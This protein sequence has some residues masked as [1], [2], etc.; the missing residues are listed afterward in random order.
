MEDNVTKLHELTPTQ[1]MVKKITDDADAAGVKVAEEKK[2]EE[3][4][5]LDGDGNKPEEKV[6]PI[7]ERIKETYDYTHFKDLT[8]DEIAEFNKA[9]PNA[10]MRYRYIE[11]RNDVKKNQRLVSERQKTIDDMTE[12]YSD[13]KVK[14]HEAFIDALKKDTRGGWMKHQDEFGLPDVSFLEKQ[15][16]EGNSI[17]D[18][19]AQYQ[20]TQLIPD[21]EKKFNLEKGTFVYDPAD[22]HKAKT[23]SFNFRTATEDKS[24]ELE[25]EHTKS[26]KLAED[27]IQ[28]AFEH[29]KNDM[30][31]LKEDYF[32][33]LEIKDN[34]SD[35]DKGTF[36]I[37]NEQADGKFTEL[38]GNIDEMFTKIKE[39][40]FSH[41]KN[42]LSLNNIFRGVHFDF[43]VDRIRTEAVENVHQQYRDKGMYLRGEDGKPLPTNLTKVQ[44]A[45]DVGSMDYL[46]EAKLKRSPMLRSVSRT[47]KQVENN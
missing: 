5:I 45:A 31:K 10:D 8:E 26:T 40:E 43:L 34:M 46:S 14:R 24:Q 28:E 42:P 27:R 39:G 16:G 15:F 32:P 3:K 19:L 6:K 1:R 22:A 36:K 41:E 25:G 4:V 12:R 33:S 35:E 13:S 30:V 21:I 18:R 17:E 47:L 44:G 38:L 11:S 23:P 20:D 7:E 9:E 29:R 2:E 37:K